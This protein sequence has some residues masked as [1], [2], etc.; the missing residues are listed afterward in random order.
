MIQG[1]EPPRPAEPI[2]KSH[3]QAFPATAAGLI[4]GVVLLI[5]PRGSP[6]EG[7][8]SFSPAILGRVPPAE[9][10]LPIFGTIVLHLALALVYG[11]IISFAVINIRELRA[12]FTG[13]IVGL[14]LYLLNLGVVSFFLPAMRGNE[15]S[16]IVT[17]FV[18]GLIA[19]G[20]YRGLLR[21]RVPVA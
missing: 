18:F 2:E 9:W 12:V 3:L 7:L 5:V 8:T 11:F 20:A 1:F 17:H 19:A 10:N 6:W 4:A 16:V 14:F 13:G 15:V 21:R